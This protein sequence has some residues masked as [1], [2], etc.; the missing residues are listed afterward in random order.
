[1]TA[2]LMS[3]PSF[4]RI[5]MLQKKKKKK[6]KKKKEGDSSVAAVAFLVALQHSVA[7]QEFALQHNAAPQESALERCC[8][9]L[10]CYVATELHKSYS[11]ELCYN[12]AQQNNNKKKA[13]AAYATVAFSFVRSC[14]ADKR[15]KRRTRRRCLPGS[16][17]GP[18]LAPTTTP[19][20]QF[21]L[22]FQA[23]G[24][25]SRLQLWRWNEGGRGWEVVSGRG[26]VGGR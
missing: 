24:S 25:S 10:L 11:V 26:E 2:V 9:R 17:V 6:K 20:L 16:R 8:R 21:Q 1:M 13:M 15:K 23:L 5:L 7:P 18:A 19:R 4:L 14:A 12:A 22:Q 3:S